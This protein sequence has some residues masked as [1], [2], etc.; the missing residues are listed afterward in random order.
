M[1]VVKEQDMENEVSAKAQSLSISSFSQRPEDIQKGNKLGKRLEE[2]E[3]NLH[4]ENVNY[5]NLL[6]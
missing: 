6:N 4:D 3:E 1:S 2:T 5:D